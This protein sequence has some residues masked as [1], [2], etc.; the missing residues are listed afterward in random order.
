MGLS[1]KKLNECTQN[2]VKVRKKIVGYE[3]LLQ[4]MK[5]HILGTKKV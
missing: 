5:K 4:V 1:M 2:I 3:M